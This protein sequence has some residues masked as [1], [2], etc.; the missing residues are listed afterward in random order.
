LICPGHTLRSRMLLDIATLQYG[1]IYIPTISYT[2]SHLGPL[3]V[4]GQTGTDRA[5]TFSL[6]QE[7]NPKAGMNDTIA[8]KSVMTF[9]FLSMCEAMLSKCN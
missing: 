3:F 5:I 6:S 2:M 8:H 9:T 7:R 4:L 1:I